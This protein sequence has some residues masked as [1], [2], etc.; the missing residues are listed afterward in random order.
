[1]SDTIK[2]PKPYA[3][4]C[5][6]SDVEVCDCVNKNHGEVFYETSLRFDM[7]DFPCAWAIQKSVGTTLSHDPKCSSVEGSNGGAGGPGFLCDCGAVIREWFRRKEVAM[8]VTD[9]DIRKYL[10][11]RTERTTEA[12]LRAY[13]SLRESGF[14]SDEAFNAAKQILHVG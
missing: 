4:C 13:R 11:A 5:N 8:G 1:M 10:S 3:F 6:S 12:R 14:T 9:D 7:I 2:V